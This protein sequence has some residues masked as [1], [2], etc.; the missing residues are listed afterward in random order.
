[1]PMSP[2]HPP[3]YDDYTSSPPVTVLLTVILL[4][5]FFLGFFS[6]YFCRCFIEN[7]PNSWHI[8]RL[9]SRNFV[10]G[11]PSVINGLD[12]SLIQSFPTIVYSSV[13]D[14]RKEKYGLECAICLVEFEDDSLLRLLTVCYHVFHQEC[15]DLWLESHKTCPVC[16][17]NLDL[18]PPDS[19]EKSMQLVDHN[20]MHDVEHGNSTE[21]HSSSDQDAVRIDVKEE[22]NDEGAESGEASSHENASK[23]QQNYDE[24]KRLERF[25][26]SHSTGHSIVRR[27]EDEE[28][29]YTLR[30]P[31]HVKVELV[32]RGH[33]FA[34]SCT[35]FGEFCGHIKAA[36][37]GGSGE[38]LCRECSSSGGNIMNK[39]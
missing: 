33:N 8:R 3:S 15:I 12:P 36:G 21:Y 30:L 38:I 28:D 39:V 9:P 5:F 32:I 20:A 23:A 34:K 37:N 2:L 6:V 18:Q 1:M 26:R 19:L 10:Y 14:F 11:D 22:E 24:D 31:E 29:R 16:R 7:M 17:G 4:I 35:T 13:K 27:R 25:S